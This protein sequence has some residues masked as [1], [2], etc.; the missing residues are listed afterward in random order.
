MKTICC[1]F[2]VEGNK[3]AAVDGS[4]DSYYCSHRQCL[5]SQIKSSSLKQELMTSRLRYTLI[6]HSHNEIRLLLNGVHGI[7]KESFHIRSQSRDK[8]VQRE[9]QANPQAQRLSSCFG[10]PNS[11]RVPMLQDCQK[12]DKVNQTFNCENTSGITGGMC[13]GML[14][15]SFIF[16]KIIVHS[17]TVSTQSKRLPI[18]WTNGKFID[19]N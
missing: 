4:E 5:C 7:T 14:F 2:R 18:V 3:A 8:L 6:H 12:N 15:F 17:Q 19:G 9:S 13:R 16:Y 11:T 1:C 10:W